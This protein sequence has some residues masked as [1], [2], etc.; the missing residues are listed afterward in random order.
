MAAYVIPPGDVLPIVGPFTDRAAATAWVLGQS[1][2]DEA[3]VRELVSAADFEALMAGAA[4]PPP[5]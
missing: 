2:W 4:E 5:D 3:E 1:W